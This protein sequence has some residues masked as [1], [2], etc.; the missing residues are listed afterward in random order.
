[1]IEEGI[2]TDAGALLLKYLNYGRDDLVGLHENEIFYMLSGASYELKPGENMKSYLLFTK[3]K[4][5]IFFNIQL[6]TSNTK[7]QKLFIMQ[8]VENLN[9]CHD[10]GTIHQ[11]KS[12]SPFG[13]AVFSVPDIILLNANQSWLNRLDPP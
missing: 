3:D 1:M 11:L 5:A 9:T 4:A 8:K 13:M 7:N 10:L 6:Y 2:V 12:N